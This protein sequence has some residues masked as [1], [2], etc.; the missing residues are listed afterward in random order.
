MKSA[1]RTSPAFDVDWRGFDPLRSVDWRWRTAQQHLANGTAPGKWED[2]AIHETLSYLS[3]LSDAATDDEISLVRQHHPKLAEAD[4]VFANAGTL[5]D[6]IEA[7]LLCQHV[8][9]VS[10]ITGVSIGA[11]LSY[12]STFFDV[13][14]GLTAMDW[15]MDRVVQI[16]DAHRRGLT[17][18]DVWKYTALAGGPLALEILIADARSL[19]GPNISDRHVLAEKMRF[20]AREF[21]TPAW[22][23]AAVAAIIN[24]GEERF[25]PTWGSD[26][27]DRQECDALN[28]HMRTLRLVYGVPMV[29]G[30]SSRG[31]AKPEEKIANNKETEI[32]I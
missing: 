11:L 22:D 1:T 2:P 30:Q 19:P 25:G 14:E 9:A 18:A 6:E 31:D 24:E 29:P 13:L 10:A 5:R 28:L 8:Q 32:Q 23:R 7:R 26:P 21:A 15:L 12:C 4:R 3:E 20:S 16:Y 27:A 17:E